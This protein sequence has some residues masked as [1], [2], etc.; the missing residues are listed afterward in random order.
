M[1]ALISLMNHPY[2][3]GKLGGSDDPKEGFDAIVYP[4]TIF[5]AFG[6]YLVYERY[7]SKH[8]SPVPF[9]YNPPPVRFSTHIQRI[10]TYSCIGCEPRLGIKDYRAPAPRVTSR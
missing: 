10:R 5:F 9:E 7:Q 8:N 1:D 3:T 2:I 4:L 6:F